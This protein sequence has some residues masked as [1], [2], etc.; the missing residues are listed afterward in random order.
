MA[1]SS[2]KKKKSQV[3]ESHAFDPRTWEAVAGRSLCELDASLVHKVT[4]RTAKAIERNPVSTQKQIKNPQTP[5][6][7]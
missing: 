4:S 1:D 3:V 6:L 7:S 5:K 2:I